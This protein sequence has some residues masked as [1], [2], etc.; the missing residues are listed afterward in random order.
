MAAIFEVEI[1]DRGEAGGVEAQEPNG[2]NGEGG[3]A[4]WLD[5]KP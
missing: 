3:E 1:G 4:G 5:L 2:W